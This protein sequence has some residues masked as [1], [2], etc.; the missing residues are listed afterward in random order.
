[1]T[2]LSRLKP[3]NKA[4]KKDEKKRLAPLGLGCL[5]GPHSGLPEGAAHG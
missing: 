5:D 2:A 4:E 1:M 3:H